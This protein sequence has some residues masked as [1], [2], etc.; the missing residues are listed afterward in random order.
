[1]RR[2]W[3]FFSAGG[4]GGAPGEALAQGRRRRMVRKEECIQKGPRSKQRKFG[5]ATSFHFTGGIERNGSSPSVLPRLSA[6]APP[7]HWRHHR[8]SQ[9][10]EE[11]LGTIFPRSRSLTM[12]SGA[13]SL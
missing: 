7:R 11:K 13:V 6:A 5:P 9:H 12:R 3:H 2:A 10:F 1:V 8:S 4:S